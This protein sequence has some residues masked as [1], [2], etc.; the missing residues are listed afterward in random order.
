MRN[1]T[2]KIYSLERP[3]TPI[4]IYAL[5]CPDTLEVKYIGLTTVGFRR[6]M[7]HWRSGYNKKNNKCAKWVRKLKKENKVFQIKYLEYF[8]KNDKKLDEAEVKWIKFFKD[9]GIVLLNEDSGG[10]NSYLLT[11]RDRINKRTEANKI[12][13]NTSEYKE[14]FSSLAKEQWNDPEKRKK[15]L[16]GRKDY[17]NNPKPEEHIKNMS[18][19]QIKSCGVKIQDD[20]G[21]IFNSMREA[22]E[23]FN[24]SKSVIQRALYSNTKL[25]GDRKLVR[26]SGGKKPIENLRPM[27]SYY[28]KKGE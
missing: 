12:K 15:L 3:K 2:L 25:L 13:F 7:Y 5:I 1:K 20:L 28:Q 8:D 11:H 26:I 18:N 6:M 17:H 23:F 4:C 27:N 24:V 21:R 14:Y 22:A 16:D 19:A 9:Q 10:R